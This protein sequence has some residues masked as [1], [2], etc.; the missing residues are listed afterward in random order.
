[1]K[2]LLLNA[3]LAMAALSA[4]AGTM[5]L[6][7]SLETGTKVKVLLNARSATS[8][9]SID[10]GNGQEVK[11]TVDPSQM[12]YNRWIE[13]T[14]AGET[15]TISGNVTEAT[16]QELQLTTVEIE[17]MVYLE[18]LNL[19]NNEITDFSLN[20]IT[21]LKNL[22]IAHNN[23]QNSVYYNTTL[24]LENCASTLT[25]L[26]VSYNTDLVCLDLRYM[27]VL[28]YVTANDCPTLGSV[29]I[30]LP[31]ES[32]SSYININLNNCDLAHFY[33][34][35]LPNLRVLELANNELMTEADDDPFVLGNYP[36]LTSI[37]VSNNRGVKSLDITGCPKLESIDISNNGFTTLDVAQA[38]EL[39]TLNA[40]GN[41]LSTIDLGNNKMLRTLNI[42][43]NPIKELDIDQ[44]P[45]IQ[46]LNISNTQISRVMLMNA[47]YLKSFRAS[48]T[49]LEFVDFNGQQASRMDVID[50]RDCPNFTGETM[51]YTIHTLPEGK[52][53]YSTAANLLLSG[54]NAETADIAYATSVD[55]KWIC[56]V[57]GD[58][59]AK[60]SDVAI[61][62][63]DATATGNRVTGSLDRLYPIFGM[64]LDYDL[65]EYT[66]NGG[67]FLVA[68]WK[69]DYFQSIKSV[70]GSALTGVPMYVYTYPEEGKKF[71]S[72]TVN[73]RTITSPWF[74]VTGDTEV[75]VNFTDLENSI[76]F[77][78]TPG[79]TLSLLVNTVENNGTIEI[80]WG[81]GTRTPYTGQKAYTTGYAELSGSRIDGSAAGDKV[82]I[83]GNVAGLDLSGYGD[84]AEWF[85]LWDNKVTA[86]NLS[87]ADNLKLLNIY[88][89]PVSSLDLSGCP[90]LEV[91][92]ASY[93]LLKTLDLSYTPNL[94][95]LEA[96]SDGYG[97]EE[98]GIAKLSSIDVTNLPI[99]Q[100][101]NIKQNDI[102]T[103]D[104]SKNPYLRWFNANGNILT[105][106]DLSANPMLET[107]DLARN[108]LTSIDLSA[109]TEMYD[110]SLDGNDIETLDLS[111]NK[112]LQIVMLS[113]NRLTDLDLSALSGLRRVYINGN[114][115]NAEQLN[116]LY[117]RLPVRQPDDDDDSSMQVSYNLAVVQG[118][119]KVENDGTGADS[120]IALDRGWT[121]SHQGSNASCEN[122]YLDIIAVPYGT[123][124]LTDEEGNVFTHGSKVPKY[125]KVNIKAIPNEGYSF[126]SFT[127]NG[128]D[129]LTGNSFEMPGIYT[130]FRASFARGAGIDS[131]SGDNVGI[132][133]GK[134]AITVAGNTT[135]DIYTVDGKL[136]VPAA[137]VSGSAQF[138]VPAGVYIVRS[139]NGGKTSKVVVK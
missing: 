92:D 105:S 50:L 40:A 121:P 56:D 138:D 53:S 19:S 79:T 124:V 109:Q 103:I 82:T 31:E 135:V 22:S 32:R 33:P 104:L 133:G 7:T 17:G 52:S 120:S 89:N 62:L 80:D 11:Y 115:M 8:P 75:A 38:T 95:W 12:A 114:G 136:I 64:G 61:T 43:D 122:A 131:V 125:S 88:F 132:F 129:T 139:A 65:T 74:V 71:Q 91:L 126:A 77:Y 87:Q 72:I 73:G 60:H 76:S 24:S 63:K 86:V 13:G 101:L 70:D 55:M 23:L 34:V 45:Y 29:F 112:A 35:S 98:E 47:S 94:M 117:Y 57:T 10:W 119:D 83:Y 85:G 102:A 128:E 25:T 81:T 118:L 14:V 21:P 3:L 116:D 111:N 2:K 26:N 30:C 41:N 84:V 49:L 107:L 16:L 137:N 5:T 96:Y 27:E 99:L 15:I 42:A 44:F 113:N 46:S 66:T 123:V 78:T 9:V 69:P 39:A 93:T 68:Q 6:T 97:D 134:N 28:E 130:K 67:K 1:M 54:S 106:V 20:D 37:N 127:L 108:K 90:N 36:S 100:Y 18:E 59:T 48:N 4:S 110:L 58:G 51:D